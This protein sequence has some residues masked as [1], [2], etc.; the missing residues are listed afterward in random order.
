MAAFVSTEKVF[1][2]VLVAEF[3]VLVYTDIGY[4]FHGRSSALETLRLV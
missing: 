4:V 2:G 1:V 3:I